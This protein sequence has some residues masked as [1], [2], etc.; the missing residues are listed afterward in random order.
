MYLLPISNFIKPHWIN[1]WHKGIYY[2]IQPRCY[3]SY[4]KN[5][6]GSVPAASDPPRDIW[7]SWSPTIPSIVRVT[8][9]SHLYMRLLELPYNRKDYN[10]IFYHFHTPPQVTTYLMWINLPA[11]LLPKSP[12]CSVEVLVESKYAPLGHLYQ[13]SYRMVVQLSSLNALWVSMRRK[14]QYF[15]WSFCWHIKRIVCFPTH[16]PPYIPAKIYSVLYTSFELGP[17][18]AIKHFAIRNCQ[19]FTTL[20]GQPTGCLSRP[21]ILLDTR[22]C[23]SSHV[24]RWLSIQSS[25]YETTDCSPALAFPKLGS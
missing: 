23:R 21:M 9:L 19:F 2:L 14:L 16:I 7:C 17:A 13:T 12:S 15:S 10:I 3:W 11:P 8:G 6:H 20:T 18:T 22:A 24:G 5:T 4:R 25:K 1:P